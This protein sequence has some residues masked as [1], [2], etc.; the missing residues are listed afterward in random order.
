MGSANSYL[1]G[2]LNRISYLSFAVVVGGA[3][4]LLAGSAQSQSGVPKNQVVLQ[5]STPGTSQSGH[6]NITGTARA[7]QFVG[8]GSGLTGVNAAQLGG[9]PASAFL[10][11][12]PNPLSLTGTSPGFIITGENHS[13]GIGSAAIYGISNSSSGQTYGVQGVTTSPQGFGMIGFAPSGSGPAVGTYGLSYSTSGTGVAG[14][15]TAT[16]GVNYGG[17][18]LSPSPDGNGVFGHAT[19]I[20]GFNIGVNGQTASASGFGVKGFAYNG[21]G[22]NYGGYFH[23]NSESGTGVFGSVSSTVGLTVGGRFETVS[24]EGIG[25]LGLS[26]TTIANGYTSG[27]HGQTTNPVGR[28]VFGLATDT[29]GLNYG[30]WGQSNSVSGKGVFGVASS[31]SGTNYGVYGQSSSA[32]GV[33]VFG[34]GNEGVKG[35]GIANG[36][37][38]T[39]TGTFGVGAYGIGTLYGVVG[40]S[41]TGT[42]VNATGNVAVAGFGSQTGVLGQA[43]NR[44]MSGTATG[45]HGIGV[46]GFGSDG[47]QSNGGYF[48]T[49]SSGTN[50]AGI[51]AEAALASGTTYGVWGQ[52]VSTSGYGTIGIATATSGTTYGIYGRTTSTAGWA[53]YADGKFGASGTKS[54]RID[55]PL[56]PE[57]KYL[58]HY[59]AESPMPQNFYVGN[60]VTDSKGYGWVELPDYFE[61]INTNFK[62]QLT[63]VDGE[64]TDDF[65][66]AKVALK[67]KNGRFLVRTNAPNVEVSWRVDADRNDLWARNNM[68]KEVEEK[69]G[70][71][72]GKYQYPEF[73]GQPAS[74]KILNLESKSIRPS[75]KP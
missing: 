28:G 35:T 34:S 64:N 69:V 43:A 25:V 52:N 10:T 41:T 75:V 20:S 47:G 32:T 67:I 68:P 50:S 18:F 31:G 58:L 33:G 39:G 15:V 8:G 57:N 55:H 61:E 65:V 71:E 74:K 27:V 59:S 56:D 40:E 54:F 46:A 63:V 73:Y 24:D 72:I 49:F 5:P 16:T 12:V 48:R 45:T 37:F 51:F 26:N 17:R 62:Y 29:G 36:L 7:G 30:V 22:P 44:G 4:I 14:E 21:T 1:E 23:S 70:S 9:L 6:S 60:V 66:M 53:V 13:N 19:A 2:A 11:S 38:G 3:G 42:G